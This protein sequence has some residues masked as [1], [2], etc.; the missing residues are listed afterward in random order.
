MQQASSTGSQPQPFASVA[1]HQDQF[2]SN[3][4]N[5]YQTM[6]DFDYATAP[7]NLF[8]DLEIPS[9]I[10]EGNRGL[11]DAS[12]A[13]GA[14]T[15]PRSQTRDRSVENPLAVTR[16][17]E[18][19]DMLTQSG[20]T[21][22][23]SGDRAT[24]LPEVINKKQAAYS[25]EIS[26]EEGA[27][28]LELFFDK[29]QPAFPLLHRPRILR[30][31]LSPCSNSRQRFCQLDFEFALL[32]NGIFSLAARFSENDKLRGC[33][34]RQHGNSFGKAAHTM[35][36]AAKQ[37]AD[38]ENVSLRF[39][40][41]SILLSYFQLTSRPSFQAWLDIGYCCRIAY[42][43]SLHQIDRNSDSQ[44]QINTLSPNDWADREEQRR[45]W[46]AIV[47]LDTFASFIGGRP[48]SLETARADVLLPVSD[49]AW[50]ALRPTSSAFIPSGGAATVWTSLVDKE[51]QDAYAWFLV[52]TFICRAAQEELEKRDR[53]RYGLTIIQSAIQCFLLGL[54]PHL[55]LPKGNMFFE[56][57]NFA[58]YNWIISIHLVI[59]SA[60]TVVGLGFQAENLKQQQN[61]DHPGLRPNESASPTATSLESPTQQHVQ[62][63]ASHMRAIR[64]W[65]LDYIASATPLIANALVSPAAAYFQTAELLASGNAE[66]ALFALDGKLLEM[67]LKRFAEY[68]GI[69]LFCLDMLEAL[70]SPDHIDT[71]KSKKLGFTWAQS[72]MQR[73]KFLQSYPPEHVA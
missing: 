39:L 14:N 63:F 62:L 66:K 49:E 54:P 2:A 57:H 30:E 59:H 6:S 48:P 8:F 31:F 53:S 37:D 17:P 18:S 35:L 70:R 26:E 40:Q 71:L 1:H 20:D 23:Q 55:R 28:L 43:L 19:V 7:H 60:R 10:G 33:A 72:T 9:L 34:P 73:A 12:F 44:L 42:A 50:F 32:L 65:S 68:W 69:G 46:W 36:E 3:Q 15:S 45:A 64:M 4:L 56:E 11:M 25:I 67:V 41:G 21:L 29:V 52:A 47:Q 16:G 38:D 22:S 5:T 58:E 51:N 61:P 27:H 13:D 24:S